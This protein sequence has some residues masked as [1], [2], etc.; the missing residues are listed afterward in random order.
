MTK[1]LLVEGMDDQHVIWGLLA[2]HRVPKV[3]SVEQKGGVDK[4]LQV[5]PVQ[6]KGSRAEAVGAV[7][8][9]DFNLQGRWDSVRHILRQIGYPDIP[10]VPQPEGTILMAPGLPKFGAWLMPNNSLTGM[11]EDFVSFLIRPGDSLWSR[12][13]TAVQNIPAAERRFI[14]VHERKASLHTWLSWQ[15]DPGTPMGQAITKRFLDA[16]AA[17]VAPFLEWMRALFVE[18]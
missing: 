5:L 16:D 8:D 15:S 12:A 17:A 9:A 10:V 14:D 11:L 18:P 7:I 1:T 4:I 6:L 2:Y 3:F 13:T